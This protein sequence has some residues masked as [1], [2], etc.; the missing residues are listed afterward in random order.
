MLSALFIL[1][2]V[3]FYVAYRVYGRQLQAWFGVDPAR[4]TPAKELTDNVDYVPTRAAVLFGHHFSSIA[5]AGPIVG[6]I[7]AGIMFG[8]LPA[9]LWILVGAVFIGGVHDYGALMASIR[10][11]GRSIGDLCRLYLSPLTY[12]VFLVFVWFALIYVLIVFLD[13]TAGT[14]APAPAKARLGGAVATS[15][16]LYIAI[17]IA[18][19]L[20]IYRF[21][22]P[23]RKA[24][25]VFV[26]LV[27]VGL[28]IGH[29]VPI[30]PK[31]VPV[32]CYNNAKYTWTAL[33]LAYCF[34]AS[35]APVWVLLQPRDFLS[36][37]LLYGCLIA[38]GVGLV[39]S[40]ISGH[41]AIQYP[42]FLGWSHNG[43]PMFPILFITVACGAVSGFHSLV[44][45]GT[46][47]KQLDAEESALPIAYGSM[48]V[49]GVLAL[50]ALAGVM[51]LSRGYVQAHPGKPTLVF[52]H[53][54]GTFC[55][56][57]GIPLAVGENFGLLAV[58]TFLLTTLDTSTRLSRFV[59]EEFLGV[60]NPRWR[61]LTTA[62]TLLLPTVVVFMRITD[63]AHPGKFIPAW[64]A[65]WPAFGTTNQLLAALALL[66]VMVWL[67]AAGRKIGFLV[68][69]VLFMLVT[70]GYALLLLVHKNLFSPNGQR[71]IG[72]VSVAMFVLALLVLAD[73]AIHW[74][75]L[76]RQGAAAES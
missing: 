49:E 5:G 59:L 30:L 56:T 21:K 34:A 17:A 68:L 29:F 69:P 27:F 70:T 76:R 15:S 50:L 61:F 25:L 60:R 1:G 57:F 35:V 39:I 37:F 16:I 72:G 33:L 7:L 45:S 73:T 67:M 24:T 10:H 66:V 52:A 71:L 28:V 9:L 22:L 6:P 38:G 26:P 47:A 51:I 12:R 53:A 19:G 42:A 13:L 58:S 23:F 48:L 20:S 18:F 75:R 43:A 74:S 55:R 63:P 3:G 44:A 32:L 41:A 40:G 8:W 54:I 11:K 4:K 64:K 62:G 46:T 2:C 14:F 36:S 31:Y 65:I